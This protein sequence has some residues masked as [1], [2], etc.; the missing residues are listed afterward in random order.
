ML[1]PGYVNHPD[2]STGRTF[3]S[4]VTFGLPV[5]RPELYPMILTDLPCLYDRVQWVYF[6]DAA[7]R[8]RP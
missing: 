7:A 6:D 2:A 3:P 5:I 4:R 1:K 8:A